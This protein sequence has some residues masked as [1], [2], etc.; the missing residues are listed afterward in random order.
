MIN[1]LFLHEKLK[2]IRLLH[3]YQAKMYP[4]T[5]DNEERNVTLHFIHTTDV[6]GNLFGYDYLKKHH[7]PGGL[8]CIASYVQQMRLSHPGSVV[9]TD[10]G[11]FLQGQPL[12]YYFNNIRN[13][14]P[15]IVA[16]AMNMMQYD[17]AVIGNHDI[18]TGHEVYDR[19]CNDVEFPVLGANVLLRGSDD[20][21]FKPYCIL[22]RCGVRIAILGMTSCA[23]PGWQPSKLWSGM[24]FCEVRKCTRKWVDYIRKNEKPQLIVGVFHSGLEGGVSNDLFEEN[25]SKQVAAEVE[26]I[27]LILYGHDH[28]TAILNQTAPNGKKVLMLNPS[29]LG[30][31]VAVAEVHLKLI[32]SNV[33]EIYIH[34]SLPKMSFFKSQGKGL[35]E[36][37]FADKIAEVEEW[38][39]KP[40][41]VLMDDISEKE[42]Y[43]GPS[44]FVDLL[45]L[46]QME[47]TGAQVSFAAPL[48]YDTFIQSGPFSVQ[49]AFSL[50]KFEDFLYCM[51]MS[52][53]EIRMFLEFSYSRWT[54][55]METPDDHIMLLKNN[56]DN[57]KRKGLMHMA[58]NFDSAAGIYYEVD[59]TQ[60]EGKKIR[61]LSMA[62]G[63]PFSEEEE[64]LVAMNS[65]RG[66]GGGELMTLGAGIA[67]YELKNR[68]VSSTEKDLRFYF[69]EFIRK[70]KI[71][72][73]LCMHLWKFIPADFTKN[74]L[75]RD[76]ILLFGEEKK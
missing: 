47:L 9:L 12:T 72:V 18:E 23:V 60:P 4:A 74:A 49:D 65:Y 25:V 69:M 1:L 29:S 28:A 16:E 6:H 66:N 42:A 62:D 64:Y 61:V 71:I 30:L 21:Y 76:R 57:G 53:K 20:T 13:D 68:I 40:L 45:H 75:Q 31:R 46:M 2:Y 73:P 63:K 15:H 8:D 43:F 44:A 14:V 52:G 37:H 41:G 33:N 54:N 10:G 59:V 58:Y 51:R 27:D 48:N 17:C 56:M 22:E 5:A 55:R 32:G 38:L 70:K 3:T 35:L 34:A 26:G 67:Q 36:N 11:D 19:F 39:K 24:E 7:L 50:Y